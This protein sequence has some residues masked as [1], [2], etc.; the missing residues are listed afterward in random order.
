[1]GCEGHRAVR[2]HV[3]HLLQDPGK[4]EREYRRSPRIACPRRRDCTYRPLGL[5]R[6]AQRR[7]PRRHTTE[8][9]RRLS[10]RLP[11]GRLSDR[12]LHS[13]RRA[14]AGLSWRRASVPTTAPSGRSA[15]DSQRRGA[16]GGWRPAAARISPAGKCSNW[17][18]RLEMDGGP[19]AEE[20]VIRQGVLMR[21]CSAA[22]MASGLWP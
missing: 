12:Q 13:R 7:L 9:K 15:P 3:Q 8:R 11:L 17:P 22:R 18:G 6:S 20:E 10:N 14:L 1:M 19:D 4:A 2:L 16:P 21:A 5:R